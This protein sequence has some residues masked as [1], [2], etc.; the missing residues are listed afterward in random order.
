MS[1]SAKPWHGA[2]LAKKESAMANIEEKLA[3]EKQYQ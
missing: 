2:W 3:N 1:I